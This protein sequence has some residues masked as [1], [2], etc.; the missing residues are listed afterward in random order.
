MIE[1][2]PESYVSL[3]VVDPWPELKKFALS[4]DLAPADS[5]ARAH[6][7]MVVILI[8]ALHKW[9]QEVRTFDFR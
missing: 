2:H 9:R 5:M 4:M 3:R 7:P 8:R 1:T 6:I